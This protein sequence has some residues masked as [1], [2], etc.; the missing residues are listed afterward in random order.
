MYRN[1]NCHV[2]AMVNVRVCDVSLAN[3]NEH[4]ILQGDSVC[5]HAAPEQFLRV[6][7][8]DDCLHDYANAYEP[9]FDESAGVNAFQYL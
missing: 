4:D 3:G 5:E 9:V 2:T 8:Y 1:E 7:E 6:R